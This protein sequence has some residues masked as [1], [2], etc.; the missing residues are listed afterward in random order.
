MLAGAQNSENYDEC[1]MLT[2]AIY[3]SEI[4]KLGTINENRGT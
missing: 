1:S 4:L 3:S 2:G